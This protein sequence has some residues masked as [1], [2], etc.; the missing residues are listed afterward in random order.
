MMMC[1]CTETMVKPCRRSS[2]HLRPQFFNPFHPNLHHDMMYKAWAGSGIFTIK[3][4]SVRKYHTVNVGVLTLPFGN[5][6]SKMA[7]LYLNRRAE[8]LYPKV[9]SLV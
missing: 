6:A 8:I 1:I 5:Q 3:S 2:S 4:F 9:Q 7:E